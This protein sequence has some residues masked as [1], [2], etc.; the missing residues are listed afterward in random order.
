MSKNNEELIVQ[1]DIGLATRDRTVRHIG[2][3]LKQSLKRKYGIKGNEVADNLLRIAGMHPDFFDALNMDSRIVEERLNDASIDS[4]SN[5]SEKTISGIEQETSAPKNKALGH[6][7]LYRE[8]KYLYGHDEAQRLTGEMYDYSLGISDSTKLRIPYSYYAHTPVIARIGGEVQVITLKKMFEMLKHAS[9]SAYDADVIDCSSLEEKINFDSVYSVSGKQKMKQYR[10]KN[11]KINILP[12][13]KVSIE[14]WDNSNG[15]VDVSRIVRHKNDCG[16]TLYQTKDGDFAFV[17]N[18]HPVYMADGTEKCA[19]KLSI[20]DTVLKEDSIPSI[21]EDFVVDENLAYF[22][23]FLLGD[24]NIDNGEVDY[25]K[26]YGKFK[27][28]IVFERGG[29][30]I[31]IYQKD[32]HNSHIK[33]IIEK[34]FDSPN[35]WSYDEKSDRQL[36]FSSRDY[37]LLSSMYFGFN[38]KE[39]SFTKHLPENIMSWNRDAKVAFICG[40]I[41]S[42]GTVFD[43][44]RVDIRMMSYASIVSLYD[45][46]RTIP[47]VVGLRKRLCGDSIN[48][49]IYGIQFRIAGNDSFKRYSKKMTSVNTDTYSE[50]YDHR[51]R[52]SVVSKI[53]RF[54]GDDVKDTRFLK[55]ELEY[56]YDITTSTGRFYANGMVQHN[57][58]AIDASRLITEGRPFGQLPSLPVQ[59]LRGYISC[60][61]E[62]IHQM[63]CHLAGAIAVGSFFLDVANV[64]MYKH[65]YT[66]KHLKRRKIRKEIQNS[67]QHFVHSVNMLSRNSVESPFTNVSICDKTK[68][69][70]MVKEMEFMFNIDNLPTGFIK[71]M[72]MKH[73]KEYFYNYLVDYIY[74]LQ[75]IYLDFFDKGAPSLNGAPYRFPVTTLCLSKHKN[76]YGEWEITEE[77]TLDD[78]C[79]REIYRY[80]VFASEGSKLASCCFDEN[81]KVLFRSS[82]GGV[83]LCSFKEYFSIPRK[84]ADNPKVFHNGFWVPFK[85]VTVPYSEKYLKIKTANKKEIIVT[86]DHLHP[87]LN[88]DVSSDKLAVGDYLMFNCR[89]VEA[90]PE[91]DKNLTYEQGYLIGAFIG[92]GSFGSKKNSLGH[93][94]QTC[95]SLNE[96][97][98]EEIKKNIDIAAKQLGLDFELKLSTPIGKL[99]P[100][101]ISGVSKFIMEWVDKNHADNISINMD[102]ITQSVAFRK[103]IIDGWYATDGGS[104]NRIYTVCKSL[105]EQMEAICTSIGLITIVDECD[106]TG[107]I[108]IKGKEYNRNY[109]TQ[110]IRFYDSK[111]KHSMKDVYVWKNNSIYFAI[112]S[113]EE[114]DGSNVAYCVE[115][116]G[117]GHEPY[118]TLP[119][120]IITHNCRLINDIELMENYAAQSNSFG[121]GGSISLGSH[122]VVTVNLPRIALEAKSFDDFFTILDGRIKD[123]AKILKAHKALIKR[124]TDAGL[125]PF[126]SNGWIKLDRMFST[127]GIIG[128]YETASAIEKRFGND[129]KIDIQGVMLK[130]FNEKVMEYS[131][132]FGIA[133]NIEQIPGESFAVRLRDA[134]ELIFGKEKM[135]EF[136]PEPL[137]SNQPI[138]LWHEADIWERLSEDGKYNSLITGGGIVHATIGEKVTKKQAKSIIRYSVKTGCEHFALNSIYSKCKNGHMTFGKSNKCPSCG[139]DI[140]DWFTRVVGF[141]VPVSAM[142]KTRRTWEFPRRKITSISE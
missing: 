138:P 125:Q 38:G 117:E 91:K 10:E 131:K 98:Y 21:K 30:T 39:N 119:N 82:N 15:W 44:G 62:T 55:E 111:N 28:G 63:S 68:L 124:L 87:T 12:S 103:G 77:D 70:N 19:E 34:V 118:F 104:S 73:N 51:E 101:T 61:T 135:D 110:C 54:N 75:N 142:N 80:N 4:N 122:R 17:T 114:I 139:E 33:K 14:V 128:T 78:F 123:A 71:K 35:F 67:F 106:R 88:G 84:D 105:I 136:Y 115:I 50:E 81:Q 45:V 109:P 37:R 94:Y 1:E 120:G 25:S 59:N 74:E 16:Y 52:G 20:G 41:D 32:I 3:S 89:A 96:D 7:Y 79:N 92:D 133:G 97:C 107:K 90:V 60:L 93:P 47:G 46:L 40:L 108:E 58:F 141:F 6:D 66:M 76:K 86:K 18:N 2:E 127:F 130:F 72:F 99:F 134:D 43:T 64:C 95:F 22:T 69:K 100:C 102:V 8:I 129:G 11:S 116:T 36:G 112:E 56:V 57:C 132:E 13:K 26:K 48:N 42:D 121:A 27:N 126:I 137:Y 9:V 23:G 85:R 29:K 53:F 140:E 65:K 31:S 83:K 49:I 5:K 24:G 113:I